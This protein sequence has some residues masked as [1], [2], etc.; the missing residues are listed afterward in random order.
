MANYAFID[1]QNVVTEIIKGN[2]ES[3]TSVVDWE[4][5]YAELR[6]G[7]R[8]RRTSY[9]TIADQHQNGGTAFRKNY[10]HVGFTWDESRNAFIPPKFFESWTLNEATCQWMPPV[11]HPADGKAYVWDES[12][13]TWTAVITSS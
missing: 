11:E 12:T 1:D 10:A 5:H 2:D 7:Q 4:Q 3:D 13:K 6:P 8:C 9:N